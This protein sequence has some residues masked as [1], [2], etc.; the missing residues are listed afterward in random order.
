MLIDKTVFEGHGIL[1]L[2]QFKN[3]FWEG[4]KDWKAV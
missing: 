1:S 4:Q 2:G 3:L